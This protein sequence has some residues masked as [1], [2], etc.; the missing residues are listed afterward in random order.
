[1]KQSL[2]FLLTFVVFPFLFFSTSFAQ[3]NT[4]PSRDSLQVVIATK[5]FVDV[6]AN[7][8]WDEFISFFSDD[9]TCFFPA[10]R[11]QPQRAASKE[12]LAKTFKLLFENARKQKTEPPYLTIEPKEIKIQMTGEVA[13]VTFHLNSASNFGRR[14]I[15]FKKQNENW[16]II[17]M[18]ASTLDIVNN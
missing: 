6:F 1:M 17:H 16:L 18:H 8:K 13:I 3:N 12:E 2:R 5:K 14:T 4:E 15:V 9:A 11:M 7:L 10:Y